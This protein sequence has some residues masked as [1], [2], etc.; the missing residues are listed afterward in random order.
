MGHVM[1]DE[2]KLKN[3]IMWNCMNG[4]VS[5]FIAD[6]LN[7][8]DLMLDILGLSSTNKKDN[9]QLSAYANQWRF[10]ST[11]GIVHNSFYYFNKGSLTA[12]EIAQQFMDIL[13]F[14]RESW[15]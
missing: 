9:R 1:M 8:K 4:E 6:E 3:G 12:N 15:C 13:I 2:I 11:R 7:A 14:L 10:R 5:G